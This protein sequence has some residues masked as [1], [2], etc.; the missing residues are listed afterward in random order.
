MMRGPGLLVF[1]LL[2]IAPTACEETDDERYYENARVLLATQLKDPDPITLKNLQRACTRA[3]QDRQRVRAAALLVK[4]C[5]K[6]GE[7]M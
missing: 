5:A 1:V 7:G 2:A 4:E 3:R 6:L